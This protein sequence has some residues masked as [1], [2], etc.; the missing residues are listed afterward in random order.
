MRCNARIDLLTVLEDTVILARRLGAGGLGYVVK[1]SMHGGLI[2]AMM[3]S[4]PVAYSPLE[5]CLVAKVPLLSDG[6]DSIMS[7]RTIMGEDTVRFDGYIPEMT[8]AK[9]PTFECSSS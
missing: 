7:T 5:S 4:L 9:S 3:G 8:S 2:P 1:Q 6:G